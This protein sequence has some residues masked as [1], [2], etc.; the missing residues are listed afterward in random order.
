MSFPEILGGGEAGRTGI[1]RA[2][3]HFSSNNAT[4][5]DFI[6]QDKIFFHLAIHFA[7]S[8]NRFGNASTSSASVVRRVHQPT[9]PEPVEGHQPTL[10][11]FIDK[12]QTAAEPFEAD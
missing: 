6:S 2:L 9:V 8:K 7:K 3:F 1:S 5:P 10:P 12:R 11:E 4:V